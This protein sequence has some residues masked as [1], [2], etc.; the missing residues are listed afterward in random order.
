MRPKIRGDPK[1]IRTPVPRM[2]ILCPNLARRQG[3][4]NIN[5]KQTIKLRA[6]V[7]TQHH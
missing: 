3:R 5:V 6:N 2:K 4:Q 7:N 1:G